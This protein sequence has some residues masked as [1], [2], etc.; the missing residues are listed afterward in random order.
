M[1]NLAING[2]SAVRTA[3]F[4]AWPVWDES[5]RAE[6]SDVLERG[7]WWATEGSAVPRFEAAFGAFHGANECA[8]V[9]NGTHA[10]EV[11]LM[12]ADVGAGD[13]V[14]VT[15]Y[16]FL[17]SASAVASVNAIP[18]LVDIDP[19]TLCIDPDAVE[20]AI[21]PRTRAI[22]AV[23]LA[24][25][26]ADLDRLTEICSRHDLAL[27][28]DCAHAHGSSWRGNPV[29]TFGMAGT[30]SFQQSKLI[31][32]GEGGAIVARDAGFAARARSFI[33]CGRRP[34]AWFYEHFVLGGNHRMTEWQAA[35]LLA[36]LARY[37]AQLEERNRNAMWL[38]DHLAAIPGVRPQVRD[39]RCTS[40]GYYCYVVS[41]DEVEFGASRDRV[42][43]AL[44]AE[45]IPLTMSYPPVHR[46]HTFVTSGGFEPRHRAR[47]G[48]PDYG[49]LDLPATDRAAA[50]TLWFKHQI[51]LERS[52]AAAVLE[53][54]G[55]VQRFASELGMP[56]DQM[57]AA[58][59]TSA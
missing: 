1:G 10:I 2:G 23:H 36:Q 51:L 56:D 3:P 40:Q 57:T 46:I 18:V 38:N 33:D 8:A 39:E 17:A 44:V 31:T 43:E 14:I 22:I 6:L 24:G 29:G 21:S 15:D 26:P 45:G 48:W 28:E 27:I 52:G 53:A 50:S 55:K 12:A 11:A 49:R 16:T 37:P 19:G 25:H 9:T 47:A 20:A 30:F 34:G 13:E 5:E 35:V 41:I 59:V 58:S 54:V 42:R 7:R 4:P 32:A